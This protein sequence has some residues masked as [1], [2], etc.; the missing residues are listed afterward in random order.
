M[1]LVG[2]GTPIGERLEG[3]GN[4]QRAMIGLKIKRSRGSRGQWSAKRLKGEWDLKKVRVGYN[5]NEVWKILMCEGQ[6]KG[7]SWKVEENSWKQGLV[8]I[9]K[10]EL[11]LNNEGL[12]F[13][14]KLKGTLRVRVGSKVKGEGHPPHGKDLSQ[15]QEV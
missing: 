15:R 13:C 11:D 2:E 7:N 5:V 1:G 4:L 10:V 8:T 6:H 14:E 9:L 3:E 12:P